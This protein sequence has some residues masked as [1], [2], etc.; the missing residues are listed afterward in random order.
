MALGL[1]PDDRKEIID[2]RLASGESAR[3]WELFRTDLY[4][5]GPEGKGLEL[6]C[7][8]G[9][10]GLLAALPVV[11]HGIAVRRCWAHKIRN[12][13]NK[14]K[15]ADRDAVKRHLHAITADSSFSGARAFAD[16]REDAYPKAVACLAGDL[17][18]LLA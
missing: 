14:V 10:R 15:A 16:R 12:I 3:E 4:R 18:D 2:F 6:I 5:R 11:Y 1:R 7:V 13:L 8:D 17:D 9:G